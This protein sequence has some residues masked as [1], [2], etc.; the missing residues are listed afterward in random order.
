MEVLTR[1]D[2]ERLK[3]P[4]VLTVGVFDGLHLGHQAIVRKVVER[5]E[6]LSATPTLITFDPH[7]RQVLKPETAPPLL[8]TFTQKVEGLKQLGIRQLLVVEFSRE[9]ATLSAEEFIEK[10]MVNSLGALEVH[11]GKGFSFG[12]DRR[13]NLDLLTAAAEKF[14]FAA[15]EV[16]EVALRGRRISSTMIRRL[17][18]SGKVN[19]ARRMLGRAYGVE[20]IVIEGRKLGRTISFPTA[21]IA[22]QNRVMPADGVYVTLA[23][24]NGVWHR[25]V[26]NVGK[27]PTVGTDLESKVET[28]VLDFSGDLYGSSLRIRFLHRLRGEKR[29]AGLP[30]LKAQIVEDCRAADAYFRTGAAQRNFTF[31]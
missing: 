15:S 27:R 21:N 18:Q 17:L 8:Q 1:H 13:G 28:H 11:L 25:S 6:A 2:D 22:L 3:K 5:A 26:T 4:T 10:Y 23:L 24:I 20:G 12:R 19:L 14:G 16:P 30:E 7:P 31:V 9:L 29:F